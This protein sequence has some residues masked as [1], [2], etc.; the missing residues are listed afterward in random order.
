MARLIG[1]KEFGIFAMVVSLTSLVDTFGDLGLNFATVQR[2]GL[3]NAQLSAL[4]WISAR[5]NFVVL[6][7]VSLTAPLLAMFYRE[8][9]L[10]Y[11]TAVAAT[12][13][14]ARGLG[15]QHEALMMREMQFGRLKAIEVTATTLGA[16]IGI[17]LAASGAGAWA[18]VAQLVAVSGTRTLGL[19][20]RSQWRPSRYAESRPELANVRPMLRYGTQ[21]SAYRLVIYMGRQFDRVIL[22]LLGGATTLGFYASA[23]RWAL[24]PIDMVSNPLTGVAVVGLS[25]LAADPVAYRLACRRGL[26]PFFSLLLPVVVFATTQANT[27][28]VTLLGEQW[29]PSAPI[30]RILCVASLALALDRV[31]KW[32][33]LSSG[34]TLRQF[35][36][37]LIFTP[38][39]AACVLAG[40]P[41]GAIGVAWGYAVGT[42]LLALP[43]L[44]YCLRPSPVRVS[45]VLG[46][47]ARP[48]AASGISAALTM[49]VA[50]T[51]LTNLHGL[52]VRALL[53][54]AGYITT[55]AVLPGGRKATGE[56]LRMARL[57]SRDS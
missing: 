49:L 2:R 1:P 55:W 29:A 27:L 40:L 45:D 14:F 5:F 25:R 37:A 13:A 26:L 36:W 48:A 6:L 23:A 39:V 18:L 15:S 54:T 44:A 51:Q 31:G 11:M 8:P 43:G 33:Y 32:I 19:W 35:R 20:L 22:G 16:V 28:V 9:A 46:A 7:V 24:Y 57:L 50:G 42:S 52:L 30:F 4:F 38:V 10:V 47:L 56:L 17:A 41:Y 21:F 34:D 3:T 12:A 53:F